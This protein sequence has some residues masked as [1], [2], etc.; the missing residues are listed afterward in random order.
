MRYGLHRMP[1]APPLLPGPAQAAPARMPPGLK[2]YAVGDVHGCAERLDL[3]HQAIGHDA[4]RA[5]EAQKVIVDLG[6]YVDRGPDSRGVVARLLAPAPPGCERIFLKGNHEVMML[7]ALAPGA[8]A[9]AVPFWLDNGGEETLASYGA[10]P[11]RP[12][13]WNAAVPPA[14]RAFLDGLRTAWSAGGYLFAHAGIRPGVAVEAQEEE[15]L[16]WIR[17]PFLSWKSQAAPPGVVVH[18]H[19]PARLPEVKP[20]RIGIDTGA[21]FGGKLTAAVLWGDRLA[22]IQA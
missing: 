8:P 13:G 3:L 9:E 14:Q 7:A 22:F 4:L 16:L 15:D 1:L 17:E 11:A 5:P 6:G 21:V 20:W 19:T 18:G 10:D 2:I 12:A